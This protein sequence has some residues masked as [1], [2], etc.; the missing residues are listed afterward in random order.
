VT[1]RFPSGVGHGAMRARLESPRASY[2]T[3]GFRIGTTRAPRRRQLPTKRCHAALLF[4]AT[5]AYQPDSSSKPLHRQPR[6]GVLG[7]LSTLTRVMLGRQHRPRDRG[8][9]NNPLDSWSFHISYLPFCW[10]DCTPRIRR[11]LRDRKS[12]VRKA[13]R[14][15]SLPRVPTRVDAGRSAAEGHSLIDA[16]SRAMRIEKAVKRNLQARR[17]WQRRSPGRSVRRDGAAI[18]RFALPHDLGDSTHPIE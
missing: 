11:H 8:R 1:P 9:R 18:A 17:C 7:N 12:E 3:P 2:A 6:A 4:G 13:G 10:G 16:R 15:F 14:D 5:R